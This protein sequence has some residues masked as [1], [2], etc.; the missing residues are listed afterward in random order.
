VVTNG[1]DQDQDQDL[2][3]DPKEGERLNGAVHK[4][5]PK[6]GTRIPDD[7]TLTESRR[8][9][10]ISHAVEPDPTFALFTT[11]WRSA[12]GTKATKMDWDQA[13][14]NWVLREAADTRKRNAPRP[15]RY[16]QLRSANGTN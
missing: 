2:N 8:A 5:A 12:S 7:F 9:Y 13:W 15:G 4:I 3:L 10:A 14:Q 1:V 6:R 11:Y 16:D